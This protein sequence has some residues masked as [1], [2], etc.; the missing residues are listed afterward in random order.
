MS[1]KS[2]TIIINGKEYRSVEEMPPDIRALYDSVM[3]KRAGTNGGNG[4]VI[5][6]ST[7]TINGKQVPGSS[8]PGETHELLNQVIR[9]LDSDGDGVLE[10]SDID[11]VV[12]SGK[13][14]FAPE[15][16]GS[17]VF[18]D[19]AAVKV[20]ARLHRIRSLAMVLLIAAA[21]LLFFFLSRK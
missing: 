16:L 15:P 14:P 18:S 7:I 2:T 5:T 8:V 1:I 12:R 21:A 19:P 20:T 4:A 9:S 10:A 11:A 17:K 6:T 13:V 3:A